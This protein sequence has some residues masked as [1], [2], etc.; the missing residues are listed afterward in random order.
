MGS[1]EHK[2][3]AR[4]VHQVQSQVGLPIVLKTGDVLQNAATC[5]MFS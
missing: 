5:C 4:I 3:L 2:T 1:L